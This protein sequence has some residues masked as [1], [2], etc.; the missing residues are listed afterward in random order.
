MIS[1]PDIGKKSESWWCYPTPS[2]G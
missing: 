2:K 1:I